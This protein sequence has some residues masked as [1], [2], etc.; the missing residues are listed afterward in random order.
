M[1]DLSQNYTD[2]EEATQRKPV[3][4][5]KRWRDDES[6]L[7]YDT[8][9]DV[10]VTFEGN[11]YLPGTL[12]SG[13]ITYGSNLE[14]TTMT[15]STS[16]SSMEVIENIITNPMEVMWISAMKLH[17]D[18][19]PLEADVIFVGQIKNTTLQGV[20]ANVNCVGFEH[21]L[22][23][24]VPQWRYQLNCNHQ[25]FDHRCALNPEDYKVTE[26][27]TLD[28]TKTILTGTDFA[29]KADQYYRGGKVY[30]ENQERTIVNHE[31]T[32][33]TIMYKMKDI[34]SG[35]D[36]D[37]TPGCDRRPETCRDKYDNI[38]HR[39]GFEN[40]PNENPAERVTW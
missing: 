14:I 4:L 28:A 34:V 24:S 17:R 40:I 38:I 35:S 6:E 1:K 18:Q 2:K 39:L 19:V 33:L 30:F 32:E 3:M 26:T 9:G 16:F 22:S 5:F 21:F 37:A 7:W 23:N 25:V 20:N 11:E 15:I 27:I 31:G 36:V 29:L 12:K 13:S 10:A 8:S